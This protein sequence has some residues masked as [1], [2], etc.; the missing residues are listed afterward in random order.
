MRIAVKSNN[1]LPMVSVNQWTVVDVPGDG[2]CLFS[3]LALQLGLD[4]ATAAHDIR[5]ELVEHLRANPRLVS[6]SF[7]Q[8]FCSVEQL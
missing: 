1:L 8:V 6:I 5:M 3:A 7:T 2:N 4:G